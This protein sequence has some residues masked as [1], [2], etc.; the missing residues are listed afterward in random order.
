MNSIGDS[1][2]GA[3]LAKIFGASRSKS[4]FARKSLRCSLSPSI[5]VGG[6]AKIMASEAEPMVA[7]IGKL[8]QGAIGLSTF[9][10]RQLPVP[11]PPSTGQSEYSASPFEFFGPPKIAVSAATLTSGRQPSVLPAVH[12]RLLKSNAFWQAARLLVRPSWTPSRPSQ[13]SS[14]LAASRLASCLLNDLRISGLILV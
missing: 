9:H 4:N 14:I 3:S 1:V 6:V 12:C 8:F 10:I 11:T 7:M 13:A 5:F 2:N